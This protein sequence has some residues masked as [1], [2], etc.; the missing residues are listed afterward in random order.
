MRGQVIAIYFFVLN[1]I[2][3]ALG[4]YII[5]SVTQYV[6][7]DDADVGKSLAIVATTASVIGIVSLVV[8]IGAYDRAVKDINLK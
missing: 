3:L 1:T 6:F 8:G 4:S 7:Q 5:A 2:A